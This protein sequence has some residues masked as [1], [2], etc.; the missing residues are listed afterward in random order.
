[1]L[2]QVEHAWHP[3]IYRVFF[4]LNLYWIIL[5]EQQHQCIYLHTNKADSVTPKNYRSW[6]M[7]SRCWRW[8]PCLNW[9]QGL[10]FLQETILKY[11]WSIWY[12]QVR[13]LPLHLTLIFLLV[14]SENIWCQRV[15]AYDPYLEAD[16]NTIHI[17]CFGSPHFSH[18]CCCT[19]KVSKYGSACNS[20]T[21]DFVCSWIM[22]K[23]YL[24]RQD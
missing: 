12:R 18:L 10:I 1:M 22:S 16:F 20:F 3:W 5:V 11:L 19:V 13:Q 15:S 17:S 6:H 24:W 4:Q 23:V 21:P 14:M 2:R 7:N 8:V 9:Y